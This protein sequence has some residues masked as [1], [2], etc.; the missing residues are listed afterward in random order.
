MKQSMLTTVDNPYDPFENFQ[1][2]YAHD[3]RLGHHSSALLARVCM[4]SDDLSESD[5]NLAIDQAID[6]IVEL[7]ASGVHRKVTKEIPDVEEESLADL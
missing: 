6:E 7:N 5:M 1:E 3:E 4:S 2:W